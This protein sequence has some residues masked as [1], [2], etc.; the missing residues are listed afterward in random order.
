MGERARVH[1]V[2]QAHAIYFSK[3]QTYLFSKKEKKDK[4]NRRHKK[5]RR[6]PASWARDKKYYSDGIQEE[7]GMVRGED[8]EAES[9]G[10]A[11]QASQG[12]PVDGFPRTVTI[13][14]SESSVLIWTGRPSATAVD[15]SR[16]NNVH[17]TRFQIRFSTLLS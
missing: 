5:I 12:Q 13:S 1:T 7:G 16:V 3:S 15:R 8:E 17:H 6:K 11:E 14:T 2:V 4:A 10:G 9:E